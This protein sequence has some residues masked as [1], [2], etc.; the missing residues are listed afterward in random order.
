METLR[1]T[2]DCV[3]PYTDENPRR[4]CMR[5]INAIVVNQEV[6]VRAPVHTLVDGDPNFDP[7]GIPAK[8]MNLPV[9]SVI[10]SRSGMK[11]VSNATSSR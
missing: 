3:T 7:G 6:R 11:A 9:Y 10:P 4:Q 8:R 2:E 1:I 5:Y